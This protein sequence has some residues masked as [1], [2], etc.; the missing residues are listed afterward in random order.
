[1]SE[2]LPQTIEKLAKNARSASLS[3]ASA[4]TEQKNEALQHIAEGL[5]SNR[6]VNWRKS[7]DLDNAQK[8]IGE[9]VDCLTHPWE[10][11]CLAKGLRQLT[12][13]PVGAIIEERNDQMG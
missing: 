12:I 8:W 9:G 3:L 1:M 11:W 5:E 4:T 2:N 10:D 7:K 13:L 6:A